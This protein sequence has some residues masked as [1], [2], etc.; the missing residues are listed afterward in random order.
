[1]FSLPDKDVFAIDATL[2]TP[3]LKS[4]ADAAVSGV[5]T[6]LFNM[7]VNPVSGKVYVSNLE[8]RNE[9]RFEGHNTT[10]DGSS[11]RG[12]IAESR[13]TVVANG[14]ATPRHLNK[15]IDY[16]VD[17][18]P[19]EAANSLAFPTSMA[20]SKDGKKLFVAAFG[21]SK[22]GVYSTSELE[23]D[24]FVP[25]S[26]DHV[27]L[28]G[29]GPQG[30]VLHEEEGL[31]YV[32]TR[33]DNGISVVSTGG[34]KEISHQRMYNPEPSSITAGRRFLYD[35]TLSSSHGDSACASCHIFGDLDS[36]A[37]DL[38]DPDG[39]VLNNPGPFAI[40]LLPFFPS[41][42][43]H[44]M[45]GPMTTQSLR[46]MANHGPMHWRGDRTGGN[47][48]PESAQPDTGSFDEDA[49]FKAFNGAFPGLLGRAGKLS[50]S[51]M[52]AFAD[53]ALQLSYPP[54]PI[55]NLDNS[56]TAAQQAGRDFY[57]NHASDGGELPSDVFHNCNGCHTL[58]P[59]GNEQFA[60][61][62]PGFF[63][64]DG[65]YS[66]ENEAQFMKVP[67]LRNLY[68]KVGMFGMA[69]T[70]RLPLDSTP[71]A[72]QFLPPPLNDVSFKGDQVRGFGFTHDGSV[73]TV[74][75][76]LGA[77]VFAQRPADDPFPN[78]FGIPPSAQGV[79]LR[80][81]VEAF[82]LAYDSNLAPVVGQQVTLTASNAS[83]VGARITLLEQRAAADECELVVTFV[84][85]GRETGAL[86]LPSSNSF[87]RDRSSTPAL[88]DAALRA[89]AQKG[90]VTF[91]A[92]P[93]GSGERIALDRNGDGKLDGDG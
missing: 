6:V 51:E 55:R 50:D 65:R 76:F 89:L 66:F 57:F 28:T 49:A 90:P 93:P 68:Q 21:S 48:V 54:N 82:L 38:G 27:A 56:L 87:V 85:D 67:H 31:A 46:G 60:V 58:D 62:K 33:F 32:L 77:N 64:T 29:G 23:A 4:S 78:P 3:A 34:K 36:L 91:T 30:V 86:Y 88:S 43:M 18:S 75:R 35:A 69:N 5:G 42:D 84:A 19:A 20:V 7:A 71:P 72:L 45:K 40:P 37:W 9:V 53:F 47:D 39:K 14:V 92:V 81:Q 15:H 44:P 1:M 83:V 24:T 80:R 16:S 41:K 2:A 10:G 22:L 79:A 13:I 12:H 59:R 73:D 25:S 63:G 8:S 74:F 26:T 17:G 70:F 61:E 11:V 52:Q